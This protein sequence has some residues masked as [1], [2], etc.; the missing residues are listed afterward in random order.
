LKAFEGIPAPYDTRKRQVVPAALKVLRLKN[1][2][3]YCVLGEL[4]QQVGWKRHDLIEKLET[5]RKERSKNF[6]AR[7]LDHLKKRRQATNHSD[8]KDLR[9]R[10]SKL[11]Y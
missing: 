1:Y 7:K 2:R 5:K 9:E 3:K 8:F 11:G 10:L 6:H 4:T